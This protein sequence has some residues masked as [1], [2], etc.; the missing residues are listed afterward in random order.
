[1]KLSKK[2]KSYY[3]GLWAEK[4]AVVFLM[5]KGYRIV[6]RN[7]QNPKGEIDILAI[8]G[9][10][11]AVVEVKARR[12]FQQCGDSIAQWKQQKIFGAVEWLLAG[13]A[14]I[15]GLRNIRECSIRFDAILIVPWRLPKH[16]KDAWRM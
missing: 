3:F 7:Y 14:K 4:V 2:K 16:L 13:R 10:V 15:A 6:A 8:K 9:K 12:N 11:L 1:M 5:L